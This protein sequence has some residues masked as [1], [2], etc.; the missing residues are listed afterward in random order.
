MNIK[1]STFEEN[2][3]SYGGAIYS[4]GNALIEED[5]SF[6]HNTAAYRGGAIYTEGTLTVINTRFN[7][8]N[9]TYRN[10]G[11]EEYNGGAAIYNNMGSLTLNTVNVLNHITDII[12][13]TGETGDKIDAAV[14]NY[15]GNAIVNNSFFTNNAGSWGGALYT[16][17]KH[18]ATDT[19]LTVQNTV[20]EGN[21]ATFGAAIYIENANLDLDNGTF[22]DNEGLGVGSYSTS[23]TQGGAILVMEDTD[24]AVPA[25][26]SIR[27]SQF[28]DNKANKGGA[29]SFATVSGESI[30]DN[31]DFINNDATVFGGAIRANMANGATL[32]VKDSYFEGNT[33][34]EGSA[35]INQQKNILDRKHNHR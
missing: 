1:G 11:S 19:T 3:A 9:L 4:I 7:N 35:I 23:S 33:A 25:S 17:G 14:M 21:V 30:V 32:E 34:P 2:T 27:N 8:N 18:T 16:V 28:Y 13:R 31:C 24:Y 26:A 12:Y 20:F 6:T 10:S 5:S 29:I 15:N 22:I